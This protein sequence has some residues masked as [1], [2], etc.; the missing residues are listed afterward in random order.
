MSGDR[1]TGN[2]NE[3]DEIGKDKST[4]PAK[5]KRNA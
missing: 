4:D 3:R 1:I 5:Q 2:D